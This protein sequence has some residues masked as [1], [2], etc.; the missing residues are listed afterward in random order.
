LEPP[1]EHDPAGE[2]SRLICRRDATEAELFVQ[3]A[4]RTSARGTSVR[5]LVLK[6]GKGYLEQQGVSGTIVGRNPKRATVRLRAALR[7][8]AG[9]YL[10]V[11]A[12]GDGEPGVVV[13]EPAG[14]ALV[15][16]AD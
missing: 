11:V 7:L 13:I 2:P 5:L 10:E 12:T 8:Q 1:F 9:D 15:V 4:L 16:G 14:T 6:N 3:L